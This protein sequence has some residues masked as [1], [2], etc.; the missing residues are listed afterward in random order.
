MC[1]PTP[2]Q[3]QTLEQ[4]F[5][6]QCLKVAYISMVTLK[7]S[8]KFGGFEMTDLNSQIH[9]IKAKNLNSI[10]FEK[11][12]SQATQ[13]FRCKIQYAINELMDYAYQEHYTKQLERLHRQG[14]SLMDLH[15]HYSNFIND[16][17]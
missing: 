8:R 3:I 14:I 12:P 10:L 13:I 7:T 11:E 17:I 1:P 5:I 15:G 9:Y 2:K 4:S 16:K 6:R